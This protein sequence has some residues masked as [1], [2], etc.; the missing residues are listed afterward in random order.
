MKPLLLQEGFR[1]GPQ[2]LTNFCELDA[3][4]KLKETSKIVKTHCKALVNSNNVN[5]IFGLSKNIE[6]DEDLKELAK[7]LDEVTRI[8]LNKGKSQS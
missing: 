7:I 3:S 4:K 8:G 1:A 6:G 2:K 5:A